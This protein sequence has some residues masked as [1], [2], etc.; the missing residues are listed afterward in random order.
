[1]RVDCCSEVTAAEQVKLSL[2]NFWVR[3]TKPKIIFKQQGLIFACGFR[4]LQSSILD[5]VCTFLCVLGNHNFLGQGLLPSLLASQISL[6]HCLYVTDAD[7][8]EMTKS[9][10]N[11]YQIYVCA[12]GQVSVVSGVCSFKGHQPHLLAISNEGKSYLPLQCMHHLETV[13]LL[14]W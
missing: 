12:W 10:A 4:P 1:M 13:V 6:W 7:I 8:C 3:E 9:S 14:Y 2:F 11:E 5:E